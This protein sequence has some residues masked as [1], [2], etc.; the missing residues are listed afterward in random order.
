MSD[1]SNLFYT[2]IFNKFQAASRHLSLSGVKVLF[3]IG[4]SDSS[5]HSRGQ[6]TKEKSTNVR[7]TRG[8]LNKA[9][10]FLSRLHYDPSDVQIVKA[11]LGRPNCPSHHLL[12]ACICGMLNGKNWKTSCY[13]DLRA[14]FQDGYLP[15]SSH[16]REM[17]I[18]SS[19]F[20]VLHAVTPALNGVVLFM[21]QLN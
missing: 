21:K 7:S 8:H 10:E 15:S 3:D 9:I 1:T 6:L 4:Q 20:I 18:K 16:N 5:G 12:S 11:C 19:H 13:S 14:L 17:K 2:F